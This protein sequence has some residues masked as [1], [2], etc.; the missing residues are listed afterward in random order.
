MILRSSLKDHL[1]V[2]PK[3]SG[4]LAKTLGFGIFYVELFSVHH[5]VVTETE[6]TLNKLD[7]VHLACRTQ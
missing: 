1:V 4:S 6:V 2:V 5:L 3:E 7:Q